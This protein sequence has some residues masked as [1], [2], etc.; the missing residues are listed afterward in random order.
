MKDLDSLSAPETGHDVPQLPCLV[1]KP[2]SKYTL[3][4]SPE[5]VTWK[6]HQMHWFVTGTTARLLLEVKRKPPYYMKQLLA[7]TSS[8]PRQ[9]EKTKQ[10]QSCLGTGMAVG[11]V[12]VEMGR[13]EH[14]CQQPTQLSIL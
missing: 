14:N 5:A 1:S 8:S 11:W 13:R 12:L 3:F 10:F 9:E 6:L 7:T 4:S 2:K